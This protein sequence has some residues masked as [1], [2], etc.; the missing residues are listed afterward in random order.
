MT[1]SIIVPVYNEKKTILEI[2]RRIEAVN[3]GVD[4][5]II[6]VDDGS[7]DGTRELLKSRIQNLESRIKVVFFGEKSR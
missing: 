2:L 4:Y 7:T 6:T 3:F 1:L 5:E